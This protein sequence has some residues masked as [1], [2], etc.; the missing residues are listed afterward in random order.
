MTTSGPV[1]RPADPWPEWWLL[2]AQ[3]AIHRYV[4]GTMTAEDL[5]ARL[6][7]LVMIAEHSTPTP[8]EDRHGTTKQAV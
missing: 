1:A 7:L 3:R 8:R 5:Q 6:D 2:S 4:A